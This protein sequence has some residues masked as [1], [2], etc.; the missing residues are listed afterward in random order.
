M[1]I[2]AKSQTIQLADGKTITIETGKLAK[3]ADGSVVVRQGGTMLLATVVS[4]TE[5]RDGIDFFPLSVDYKEK[6]TAAGKFPGGYLKREARPS[7]TEILICRL[8]D[9]A[10]RPLFPSDYRLD[11]QVMIQLI[12]YDENASAPEGLA[13]LA[14]SA[15]IAV[16]DIPFMGPVSE[17]QVA[18]VDG[19]F[20]V[21]PN[22]AEVAAADIDMVIAASMENIMMVEGEMSEVSEEEM[23]EAIKVA[24]EAIKLHCQAQ[25]DLAAQVESS[26]IKRSYVSP[27]KNEDV[28]AEVKEKT[29]QKIYDVAIK[30]SSKQERTAAFNVIY[31]ELK[32]SYTAEQLAELGEFISTGFK[33]SQKAAIRDCVLN[34][35]VRLD[36]RATNKIRPIWSE[37]DY[38]PSAHGSAVFT[39]G[40]TQA[41]TSLALG[42]KLDAQKSDGVSMQRED[43]FY[44]HY[45]FPPFST[46]EARPVRGVSRREIGHGNLAWRG[47]KPVVPAGD[48]FP[49]TIRIVSDILESNGSSSMASVCAGTLALMDAGIQITRPV[50]GIA[51]GLIYDQESGKYAVLSDI[52]GDE[53]HLGDMDFKVT[54]TSEGI[55]ATQMDIKI[56]GLSY[57]VLVAA[58]F[59]A[60]EGRLHILGEMAK[61]ISKPNEE[62]KPH[63]PRIIGFTISTEFMG[64][65][66]GP[67]GKV[68]QELQKET[69]TVIVLEEKDSKIASVSIAGNNKEGIDKAVATIKG[70]TTVPEAGSVYKGKVKVILDFGAIIEFLPGKEGLLHIS[71]IDH[72]RIKDV[73]D[74]L[75]EGQEVEIKI[76]EIDKR[77]GKFKLSRKALLPKPERTE[78]PKA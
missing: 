26:K 50:S 35:G 61:T 76:L 34:E 24:H 59:Q 12:S 69:D 74:E 51:M 49:Y 70:I 6:Y 1:S 54:G 65:I 72:K 75:T 20:I 29:Y 52:L 36:G 38:L 5:L 78:A 62:F 3:Q 13:G 11:T 58:L 44:L 23:I 2:Q 67:G 4:S 37:V 63:S 77:S 47:L 7:E 8:V 43:K 68:I 53:D 64:A 46:G 41:L 40:E 10:L 15:A 73:K 57:E 9:R 32:A 45:N 25:I 39:R 14:A 55:T 60:K 66:I 71:E 21:N 19:K 27:A 16:S 33:K 30:G 31:D 56:D 48:D 42:T 17:V 18:R 22:K 28:Y